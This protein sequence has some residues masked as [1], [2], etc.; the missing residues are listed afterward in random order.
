MDDT[1]FY[2][3]ISWDTTIYLYFW[4]PQHLPTEELTYVS[5]LCTPL[6]LQ[7]W[8]MRIFDVGA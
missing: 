3:S 7:R 4:A 2:P 5:L 1:L 6:L 8:H